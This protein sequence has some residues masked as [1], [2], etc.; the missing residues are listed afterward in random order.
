MAIKF[1]LEEHEKRMREILVPPVQPNNL[2]DSLRDRLKR[3][4]I[5]PL[6]KLPRLPRSNN[7]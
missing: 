6:P 7:V 3:R 4:T 5:A 1:I 2:A